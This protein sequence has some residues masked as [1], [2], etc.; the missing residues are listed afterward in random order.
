M[1]NDIPLANGPLVGTTPPPVPSIRLNEN[2]QLLEFLVPYPMRIEDAN[3]WQP[4]EANIENK[5]LF[6]EKPAL[7]T[8]R[9]EPD[10]IVGNETADA[11][12]TIFRVTCP[13]EAS[14]TFPLPA[15]VW[16]VV[17]ELL[18]WIRVKARHYWLLHGFESFGALY[19]GSEFQREGNQV[20]QRNMLAYGQNLIV[21]PLTKALWSSMSQ[22]LNSKQHPPVSES[23][24]CDALV[25]AV[26][27]DES[28]A[29]LELGVAAEVEVTRMLT[30]VAN[31]LPNSPQ[32]AKF[33][34]KGERDKFGQKFSDW[35]LR[36]GLE[37]APAF[38]MKGLYSG[39]T[40]IVKD[41]YKMRNGVAHSG[42]LHSNR[43]IG[44]YVFSAN[45][46]FAYCRAQREKAGVGVYSY[47]AGEFPYHQ[48]IG[49]RTGIF[50]IQTSMTTGR[51]SD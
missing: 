41:L 4:I 20:G 26:S 48:L 31:T 33:R 10:G 49:F 38:K 7:S 25:S 14:E 8:K 42:K 35:P 2:A 29:V 50:T 28:K 3:P 51:F 15:D 18:T 23:L 12:C 30:E 46:L 27:G 16:S 22:Q 17:E 24:F 13:K 47:P 39:W 43:H 44:E 36:L 32:K 37:D 9:L 19:R 34:N 21:E 11:F 5:K 40:D 6:I 1:Q 45:A